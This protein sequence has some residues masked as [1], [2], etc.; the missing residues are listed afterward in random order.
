M[1]SIVGINNG[2]EIDMKYIVL[3]LALTLAACGKHSSETTGYASNV[4]DVIIND[5]CLQR[6]IFNEC[7]KNLPAGPVATKYNDWDEVVSEC[8]HSAY[9]LAKRRRGVVKSECEGG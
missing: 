5:M 3:L 9:Y 4:D 8:R 1:R 7:M 6:E 2:M